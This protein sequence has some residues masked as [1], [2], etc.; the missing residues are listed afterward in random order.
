MRDV[1]LETL[2][3]VN[4]PI[5]SETGSIDYYCFKLKNS[6]F[7]KIYKKQIACT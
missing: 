3:S 4:L 1:S 7:V 2:S 5:M 6:F